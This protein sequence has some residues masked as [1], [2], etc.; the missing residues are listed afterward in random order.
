MIHYKLL[1]GE[2]RVWTQGFM[3]AK[4][5]LYALCHT[6]S[7]FFHGYFGDGV[8]WTICLGWS[9][10]AIILISAFQ[11][12]RI[13]GMSHQCLA[14]IDVS[15]KITAKSSSNIKKSLR[16][17]MH[18]NFLR[19]FKNLSLCELILFFFSLWMKSACG[20]GFAL[21]RKSNLLKNVTLC[22]IILEEFFIIGVI[23]Q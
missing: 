17:C 19:K 7:P 3:L 4:E 1:F 9:W 6:S 22:I 12:G 23:G 2:T 10:T 20:K 5:A 16:V 8:S 13:T 14:N 21:Y 18:Q 11:I 15:Q